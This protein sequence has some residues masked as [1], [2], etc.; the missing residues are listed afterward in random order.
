LA[1]SEEKTNHKKMSA[2]ESPYKKMK[3]TMDS[4]DLV[5]VHLDHHIGSSLLKQKIQ[6]NPFIFK[7]LVK[8][9][10][11]ID[12]RLQTAEVIGFCNKHG[13]IFSNKKAIY[14]VKND[15]VILELE[16]LYATVS[17]CV[18]VG[19][20]NDYVI[21]VGDCGV[22]R[23]VDL[24]GNCKWLKEQFHFFKVAY[25]ATSNRI[26]ANDIYNLYLIEPKTGE[27][28]HSIDCPSVN[29]LCVGHD[30]KLFVLCG[31]YSKRIIMVLY[32]ENYSQSR[33]LTTI[34]EDQMETFMHIWDGRLVVNKHLKSISQALVYV[35]TKTGK[36]EDVYNFRMIHVSKYYLFGKHLVRSSFKGVPEISVFEL[37]LHSEHFDSIWSKE[38]HNLMKTLNIEVPQKCDSIIYNDFVLPKSIVWF[39]NVKWGMDDYVKFKKIQEN[40]TTDCEDSETEESFEQIFRLKPILRYQRGVGFL[41]GGFLS[42]WFNFNSDGIIL[43]S[44]PTNDTRAHHFIVTKIEKCVGENFPIYWI[45]VEEETV[46][47]NSLFEFLSGFKPIFATNT[48]SIQAKNGGVIELDYATCFA[49]L[50]KKNII[51]DGIIDTNALLSAYQSMYQYSRQ[52]L[53]TIPDKTLETKIEI[54]GHKYCFRDLLVLSF[55]HANDAATFHDIY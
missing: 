45:N 17:A 34:N 40:V 49:E 15:E 11:L 35:D 9:G 1:D 50:K 3:M 38:V 30:G 23:K 47:Q 19:T 44:F 43:G 55:Q 29:N 27:I 41:S 16:N 36:I 12:T 18:E 31:N 32:G 8:V 53:S 46:T 7:S 39:L 5:C 33:I 42:D 52:M 51:R 25:D 6:F 22:L 14:F 26:I 10:S 28:V 21:F 4:D 48:K 13:L 20:E 54:E 24:D 2:I 37:K